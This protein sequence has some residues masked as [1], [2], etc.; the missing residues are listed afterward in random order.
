MVNSIVVVFFYRLQPI[1][2]DL[3]SKLH[4]KSLAL[5]LFS[6]LC[7]CRSLPKLPKASRTHVTSK[8][9]Q[10]QVVLLLLLILWPKSSFFLYSFLPSSSNTFHLLMWTFVSKFLIFS[11]FQNRL[12]D[13]TIVDNLASLECTTPEDV[14]FQKLKP[15]LDAMTDCQ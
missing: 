8:D 1:T 13:E 9:K 6:K 12:I 5:T 4:E 11:I 14:E 2:T 7:Q 3:I 10:M 15:T